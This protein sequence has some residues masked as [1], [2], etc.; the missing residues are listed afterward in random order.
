MAGQI[1]FKHYWP[2]RVLLAVLE[3]GVITCTVIIIEE[4]THEDSRK[5]NLKLYFNYINI[6]VKF[7]AS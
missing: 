4:P 5:S 6:D 3:V 7:E 2:N 1:R